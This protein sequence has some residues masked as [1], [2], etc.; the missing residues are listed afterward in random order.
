MTQPQQPHVLAGID[1]S[2]ISGA[3]A[4]YAAWIADRVQAPL[5]LLHNIE[6][7]EPPAATSLSGSIGLGSQQQLL[8]ELTEIEAKRSRILLEQGKQMLEEAAQRARQQGVEQAIL[9]QRHGGLTETLIELEDN[10]RVLVLGVRGETHEHQP[11][12]LGTQIETVI[13]SLHKPILVVNHAFERPDRIM[14]AYDGSQAA[15][16]ALDML[17]TSPLYKGMHCHLVQVTAKDSSTAALL[18]K[19]EQRLADA[20]LTVVSSLLHGV[21][22]VEL[23]KYQQQHAIQMI[24]MGSFGHSR[25]RDILLGSFTLKMLLQA[26]IPLLLLR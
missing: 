22:E 8:E 13:R 14:L 20:G 2:A 4:D 11:H 16:K 19:A 18:D 21:A 17:C 3:V 5:K 9:C 7:R 24:V 6:H 1:G 23:L 25:L 15:Q 10:I 26:R 12:K